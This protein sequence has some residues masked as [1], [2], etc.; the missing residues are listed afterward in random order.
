MATSLPSMFRVAP[1][2]ARCSDQEASWRLAGEPQSYRTHRCA[3]SSHLTPSRSSCAQSS[4]FLLVPWMRAIL[5]R[6]PQVRVRIKRARC[7]PDPLTSARA[8]ALWLFKSRSCALFERVPTA[9]KRS[10][11]PSPQGGEP[12][13]CSSSAR[14]AARGPRTSRPCSTTLSRAPPLPAAALPSARTDS[15]CFRPLR[16]CAHVTRAR[17]PASREGC[18]TTS[19][20]SKCV[21]ACLLADARAT[22]GRRARR[23]RHGRLKRC[24][25]DD[26]RSDRLTADRCGSVIRATPSGEQAVEP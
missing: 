3:R 7:P 8:H 18:G 21:L 1:P 5:S 4:F 22:A 10:R 23:R 25:I 24:W 9:S 12:S 6:K 17:L 16:S 19:A 13:R 2:C 15:T 26:R 11:R 20:D 14:S